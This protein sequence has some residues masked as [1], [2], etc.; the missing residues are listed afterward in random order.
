MSQ[1]KHQDQFTAASETTPNDPPPTSDSVATQ[2]ARRLSRRRLFCYAGAGLVGAGAI[3]TIGTQVRRSRSADEP[4][5]LWLPSPNRLRL[6]GLT[7]V[8]PLDGSVR[9]N[10]SILIE[11]SQIR[12]VEAV[13]V[14]PQEDS[15]LHIDCAGGYAVPG[16][17]NMHSHALQT[18]RPQLFLATMLAEGV[19]GFRQMAGTPDLLAQ[20]RQRKLPIGSFAP[21]L[22]AMP[23]DILLP[24]NAASA[25]DVTNEIARQQDQGADFVKHI[26][27]QRDVFF[28]AISA[29][30]RR[31]VRIAG[32]LPGSVDVVEASNA[33]F[34]SIE[35][36]GTGS[37]LWI[38]S[39]SRKPQLRKQEGTALPFPS[40]L[41]QVPFA[42]D[43][44]L[45]SYNKQLI[46]N[47]A[48]AKQPSIDLLR[49]SLQSYDPGR[50]DKLAALVAANG[51]WQCPTMVRLRTQ[52]LAADPS[53]QKDPWLK[54][55]SAQQ[56]NDYRAA[57]AKFDS[58]SQ[59]TR[60]LYRTQYS[61][62]LEV[63]SLWHQAGIRLLTGTDGQ[64]RSPGQTL[65]AEF[66]EWAH[67]GIKPLEIL[68]STTV[69]PAKFLGRERSMGRI[70]PGATADLVILNAD[71]LA[72]A[73][74]LGA[75]RAVVRS[76][77]YLTSDALHDATQR[78]ARIEPFQ[79]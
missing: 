25:T 54:F 20:R 17:N 9:H 63:L 38:D 23:G 51:T 28:A 4:T 26:L 13:T 32:H 30:H 76:G 11:G 35:H 56:L 70:V 40:W 57:L 41:A 53:Y 69:E 47:A 78:L 1:D 36:F 46:N 29:A 66:A 50:A 24:F 42:G 43:V 49:E 60:E 55:M 16:Y 18:D 8:D 5:P 72:D 77:S 65:Q 7:V 45:K 12:S 39:S 52:Y 58:L 71:P 44:F 14:A 33:G 48:Y 68:R 34:D 3:A 19:T 15:A 79:D 22:L 6:D 21:A 67:A 75:I 37:N 27:V 59:A 31:N 73:A 64:G 2:Q 10:T 62:F 74:N 61:M